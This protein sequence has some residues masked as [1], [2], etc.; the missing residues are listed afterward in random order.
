MTIEEIKKYLEA[1][2]LSP[3]VVSAWLQVLQLEKADEIATQL[4]SIDVALER[5]RDDINEI[6]KRQG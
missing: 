5:I 2:P 6:G 3:E 4:A 1:Q